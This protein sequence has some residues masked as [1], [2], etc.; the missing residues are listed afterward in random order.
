M[1]EELTFGKV[2][3]QAVE[4]EESIL[5]ALMLE[6]TAIEHVENILKPE[7]FYNDSHA[8]IYEA[9]TEMH[10]KQLPIDLM[11]VPQYF[12]KT[13]RNIDEVGGLFYF[14]QLTNKVASTAHIESHALIL[15]EKYL[16][17]EVIKIQS[18]S[19]NKAFDDSQDVEDVLMKLN[20][21]V[22][23]LNDISVGQMND[24]KISSIARKCVSS[25]EKRNK[26]FTQGITNGIPTGLNK[27]DKKIIGFQN[28]DLVILAGRPGSG[29]TSLLNHFA[30]SAAEEKI[31]CV[32]YSL[33][34]ADVQLVDRFI[35][36]ESGIDPEHYK[37]G[38]MNSDDWLKLEKGLQKVEK[39]PIIIDQTPRVKTNYIRSTARRLHKKGKCGMI[40]IDYL[41]LIDWA[42]PKDSPTNN[43]SLITRELK[44]LA[45]E[46]DVPIILLSQL[47]REVEK[48]PNKRPQ[49]SDLRDSGSIEQDADMVLFT[50]RPAYYGLKGPNGEDLTGQG[51]IIIAKFRNGSTDDVN[52]HHNDSLT[53][54]SDEP[55]DNNL[56]F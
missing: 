1:K 5:G 8:K 16:K 29:K 48:R 3:P 10:S 9:I 38:N 44:L 6:T 43:I 2:P 15:F 30:K 25:V 22:E 7:C 17:R 12:M 34:M 56:P 55:M 47:N 11:T 19:I 32:I 42:N 45:K 24:N 26:N 20:V 31:P 40:F 51:K 4:I 41:Q 18:E 36:G 35:V 53:K 52:F 39:L 49:L 54:I 50:Y 21:D 23:K 37:T 13:G 33:E 14:A 28:S 46:L 27:F